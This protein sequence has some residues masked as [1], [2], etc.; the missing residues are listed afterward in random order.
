MKRG[1]PPLPRTDLTSMQGPDN[2]LLPGGTEPF[3]RQAAAAGTS[4]ATQKQV[5]DML[6]P[7]GTKRPT[8]D[9]FS[10]ARIPRG[11][12][13]SSSQ[14]ENH[15]SFAGPHGVDPTLPRIGRRVR[16]HDLADRPLWAGL[17]S[18]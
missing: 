17:K 8:G 12:S 11:E 2:R 16:S 3:P 1:A 4:H 13:R 15:C 14:Y 7:W 6:G 5:R 18:P 9:A 10:S